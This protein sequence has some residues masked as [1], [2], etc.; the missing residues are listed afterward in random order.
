MPIVSTPTQKRRNFD[1]NNSFDDISIM[2]SKFISV[3][4]NESNNILKGQD[5][6]NEAGF[7]KNFI[8][9][10]SIFQFDKNEKKNEILNKKRQ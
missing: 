5:N 1:F 6:Q 2:N 3:P 8:R 10:N 4:K 9:T 7:N